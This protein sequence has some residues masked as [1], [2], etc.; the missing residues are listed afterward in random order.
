M[1]PGGS[2]ARAHGRRVTVG[3]S[4]VSR[5]LRGARLEPGATVAECRNSRPRAFQA[6]GGP[7]DRGETHLAP[8][9]HLRY[10]L[11][12]ETIPLGHRQH[13][14]DQPPPH[15][16]YARGPPRHSWPWPA[17]AATA[18][19]RTRQEWEIP[20][21]YGSYEAMLETPASTG[22][23]SRCPI[24]FTRSGRS[25]GGARQARV[26][27]EA[28]CVDARRRRGR[29]PGRRPPRP[30]RGRSLHVPSPSADAEDPCDWCPAALSGSRARCAASSGSGRAAPTTSVST[31]RSGGGS[32]WDVG[33]Y[34]IGLA[35]FAL[36]AEPRDVDGVAAPREF[37]RGRPVRGHAPIS[38]GHRRAPRLRL[39]HGLPR[40]VRHRRHRGDTPGRRTR[41]GRGRRSGSC[42][43]RATARRSST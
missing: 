9:R 35:R 16:A 21:A 23:T 28:A 25:G 30:R 4:N 36:G 20:T 1:V 32:L 10:C 24:P 33:C 42:C 29:P 38:R 37:R 7:D 2:E 8:P 39:P 22:S 13:G 27:R 5:R 18:P 40:G 12:R 31:R 26:V 11:R 41:S 15:P 19:R 34:P 17:A 14:A 6:R 43:R 3:A